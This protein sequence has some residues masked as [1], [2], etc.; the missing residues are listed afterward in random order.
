MPDPRQERIKAL[1]QAAADLCP[2]E[3]LVFLDEQCGADAGLRSAV[4]S[5]LAAGDDQD[6]L[7]D[8]QP[9]HS[10]AAAGSGS[11]DAGTTTI[12][13]GAAAGPGRVID[14]Y[15]LLE[16]IG[17][18]GM[19]EVWLAE[20][21]KPVVRRVAL[22]L[23]KAGMDT[24]QV[25]ARFEAERQ[26]LA[27]MDHPA[28]ATVF[29]AGATPEGRP[30]FVM[31]YVTGLP[32][33]RHC[34]QERLDIAARL[35]LFL[36]VCEGVQHAHQKAIL[37]RDLK[38]SNVLVATHDGRAVPKII[39]FGVAKAMA[40]PLTAHT[41]HTGLGMIVGT[42][43][44]MSPEQADLGRQDV[45]TRT[46]VYS[47]GVILYEL[48]VGV[49]PLEPER[50]RRAGW[51]GLGRVLR[52]EEPATPSKRLTRLPPD[53]SGASARQRR[54]DLPSLR[55]HV[56]GDLDWITMK[57]IEP[58][59]DR[60]YGSPADLAEDI[61]RHLRDEPVSAAAP[62]ATYRVRK[63]VR[64]HRFGVAVTGALGVVVAAG[65]VGTTTGLVRAH[66]AEGEARNQAAASERVAGFLSSVLAS[67]DPARMGTT[68]V[69]DLR[70]RV[71]KVERGR[72]GSDA[73]VVGTLRAFDEA[74][75]GIN[76]VDAAR[77]IVDQE[78]LARAGQSI[79]ARMG[80]DPQLAARLQATLGATYQELGL[81]EKAAAY[82]LKALETRR[83]VL[84]PEHPDTLRSLNA[85]GRSQHSS[86]RIH[87]AVT[88]LQEAIDLQTRVLGAD[89]PDT[90]QSMNDLAYA[91]SFAGKN[92]ES[93]A[94]YQR[95]LESRLRVLG[96]DAPDTAHTMRLRADNL[97]LLGRSAEAE[98]L[99]REAFAIQRRVLGPEHPETLRSRGNMARALIGLGRYADAERQ[100]LE[101]IDIRRRI[102]GEDSVYT[103]LSLGY[104][105]MG[106]ANQGR[107]QEAER[108]LRDALERSRRSEASLLTS[109]ITSSLAPLLRDQGRL[110]EEEQLYRENLEVLRASG[111][112]HAVANAL[113]QLAEILVLE[114]RRP[115]A[116]P[117][118]REA[119]AIE[120]REFGADHER[121]IRTRWV[122]AQ[123]YW[124]TADVE[125]GRAN[126][127]SLLAD[128]KRMAEQP[129]VTA[130]H[131]NL[132]AVCL[133]ICEP[134]DV[135]DPQRALPF[136]EAAVAASG[137]KDA[138]IL[139]TL[140]L[141]YHFTGRDAEALETQR[142]AVARLPPGPSPLREELERNLATFEK[143][144]Q[145]R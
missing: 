40:Q 98:Q 119:A 48:L 96:P 58:E 105:G 67:V 31:E 113:R 35:E 61:R 43:G 142:E 115:E 16:K 134:P 99:Y 135:R 57:A 52:E 42:P 10:A 71:E 118:Y 60:R 85:L 59:R 84:G 145:R 29:D 5:L 120:E 65:L 130:G 111:M 108:V 92:L 32:I 141:A 133:L 12:T 93:E 17:E 46:D 78:I 97:V 101:V 121:T 95:T 56:S 21:Q 109:L 122:L 76:R 68:L 41:L 13:L 15:R 80:S 36:Q 75:G 23:I 83:R 125:K 132:Y 90:L 91:M 64:R 4:E 53:A 87:E 26:A 124:G 123:L 106:Y 70:R 28:I 139:D 27:L 114:N 45:D 62:T 131:L 143:A 81:F 117:L 30:Y 77:D 1:F 138:N 144:T 3:R 102:S 20:Q 128:L 47:L 69:E 140:A 55:R 14:R 103:L 112:E 74:M 107:R 39:D 7:L 34:D 72:G 2:A 9:F 126:V 94:L 18:G 8:R 50:L 24:A 110:S 137:R 22:K 129:G 100:S 25:I 82:Q 88:T 79:E 11:P 116:E 51:E 104:L 49:L 44:Y 54:L 63:F 136:A 19:G 37:H 73:Q 127:V 33:T 6:G 86:G 38:P 66:R 89:H